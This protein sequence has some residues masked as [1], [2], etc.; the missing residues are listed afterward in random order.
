MAGQEK[1]V[2]TIRTF[3]GVEQITPVYIPGTIGF[4]IH[5]IL[6]GKHRLYSILI[7]QLIEFLKIIQKIIRLSLCT[8][9]VAK[10]HHFS[11]QLLINSNHLVI[12]ILLIGLIEYG[13]SGI[14]IGYVLCDTTYLRLSIRQI[15]GSIE[16]F[17]CYFTQ[18]FFTGIL[19]VGD[20][21]I[22]IIFHIFIKIRHLLE[23]ANQFEEEV[24]TN[25]LHFSLT[26]FKY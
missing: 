26:T 18:K 7:F 13:F 21:L 23:K 15:V 24:C 16:K 12:V 6:Y 10:S 2:T 3:R 5:R 8:H 25:H 14:G 4:I 17:L 20:V 19:V 9:F 11:Q 1:S 22:V